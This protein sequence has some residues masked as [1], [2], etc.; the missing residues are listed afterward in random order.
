M[1]PKSP[2]LLVVVVLLLTGGIGWLLFSDSGPESLAV[3]TVDQPNSHEVGRGS[4]ELTT[5]DV[6]PTLRD[7][8]PAAEPE[9][10]ATPERVSHTDSIW[11]TGRIVFPDDTPEDELVTVIARGRNFAGKKNDPKLYKA[12]AD[13]NGRFRVAFAKGTKRGKLSI[14]AKYLY[15]EKSV[16]VVR[17]NFEQEVVLEPSLGG[18]IDVT[19]VPVSGSPLTDEEIDGIRIHAYG[20]DRVRSSATISAEHVEGALFRLAGLEPEAAYQADLASGQFVNL[21][22]TPLAVGPGEVTTVEFEVEIGA[23]IIGRVVDSDGKALAE[24]QLSYVAN[25]SWESGLTD[26]EGK[27]DK[28]GLPGGKLTVTIEKAD[29]LESAQDP[30]ELVQGE[31]TQDVVFVLS[32]GGSLTGVVT[33]PDGAPVGGAQ[34]IVKQPHDSAETN[35]YR[36]KAEFNE[37]T[38]GDGTFSLT[39]LGSKDCEISVRAK[40]K[41]KDIAGESA[42]KR[43]RRLKQQPYWNAVVSGVAPNGGSVTFVLREGMAV[44]GFVVDDLGDAISR[45]KVVAE[46]T[47]DTPWNRSSEGRTTLSVK[48]SVDGSFLLEGLKSGEFEIYATTQGHSTLRRETVDV[49][50]SGGTIKLVL[51]RE[52]SL[53]GIVYD[54]EG[55][56]VAGALVKQEYLGESSSSFF[57]RSAR[58]EKT[59]ED[60]AFHFKR[61]TAGNIRVKAALVGLADSEWNAVVLAP[62]QEM[63][64]VTLKLRVGSIVTGSIH[65]SVGE[66]SGLTVKL[67][68]LEGAGQRSKVS[69]S[70]GEFRFEGV[71]PGRYQIMFEPDMS[72][73]DRDSDGYWSVRE[74]RGKKVGF[75]LGDGESRNVVLGEPSGMPIVVT[76]I[77]SVGG[78]PVAKELISIRKDEGGQS[79][80]SESVHTDE[81]GLYTVTLDGSGAYRFTVGEGGGATNSFVR[82]VPE[83]ERHRFDIE[84]PTSSVSGI[85]RGPSGELL[86]GIIVAL[87]PRA[88]E[89]AEDTPAYQLWMS[90]RREET[91]ENGAFIFENLPP[92]HYTLR[93]GGGEIWGRGQEGELGRQLIADLHVKEGA[94]LEDLEINLRPAGVVKCTVRDAAGLPVPG[95][96]ISVELE[97]GLSFDLWSGRRTDASGRATIRGL[98]AGRVTLTAEG[99]D[100]SGGEAHAEVFEGGTTD[101]ELV[102]D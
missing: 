88:E 31:T 72:D 91:D 85:V 43:K 20:G 27:F 76:G 68:H 34:V 71:V 62:A 102:L 67:Q 23:R 60:G 49:P 56:P 65:P 4:S 37:T 77:V 61:L 3:S 99:H 5:P 51:P 42:G 86:S 66:V 81:A 53:S 8:A 95:V 55:K 32:R 59:D 26:E 87:Q 100:G 93:A 44:R 50:G 35:S 1:S 39:G 70:N 24:V 41:L 74:S 80:N 14:E 101:V 69:D 90:F 10:V 52:A 92:F 21:D 83:L 16:R 25:G 84:L 97:D 38:A 57:G 96:M 2:L 28:G 36:G 94:Q 98:A 40:A 13:A 22:G 7:E 63:T 58:T 45:F 75:K 9:E 29:F 46:L 15:L 6:L 89:G 79:N 12:Q 47:T 73:M 48:D 82:E 30:I 19:V 64:G 17:K 33:W 78:E 54:L 11:I 18:C